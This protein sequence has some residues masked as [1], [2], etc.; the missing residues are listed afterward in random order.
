MII[1]FLSMLAGMAITLSATVYL[2]VGGVV[3]ALLFSN[4]SVE[5]IPRRIF[6]RLY[7]L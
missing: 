7:A 6:K 2:S 1:I 4:E 3:G 5:I